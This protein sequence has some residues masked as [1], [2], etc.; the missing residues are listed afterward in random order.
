MKHG[1]KGEAVHIRPHNVHKNVFRA[2]VVITNFCRFFWNCIERRLAL[3][4]RIH[5]LVY[6]T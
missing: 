1:H 2:F 3:L 5:L 4:L 6:F